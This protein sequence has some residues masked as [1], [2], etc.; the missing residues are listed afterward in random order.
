ML[1]IIA[2][3]YRHQIIEAPDVNSTRPTTD[4]VREAVMSA[5]GY[6]ISEATILDL[7][8]G[9]GALGLESLSRGAKKV[10]F[11]D[12]NIKAIKTIKSN[13]N[14]LKIGNE[15]EVIFADY[16]KCLNKLKD[17]AIKFDIVF[18][19]PPYIKKDLYNKVV[20]FLFDNDMLTND[21]IIIKESNEKLKEDQRFLKHKDYRYGTINVLIERR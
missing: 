12:N 8:A 10:Y 21:A 9:S 11:C 16:L 4:K 13:I 5:L 17:E 18:L 7:F 20:D 3:L 2:G 1:R 14:R 6:A 15:A 19:D